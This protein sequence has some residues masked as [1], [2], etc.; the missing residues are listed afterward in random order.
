MTAAVLLVWTALA[1][2]I[3]G[4]A[5]D[6]PA[7]SG[8]GQAP[9]PRSWEV[10][11][12]DCASEIGRHRMTLFGNGT[13]RIKVREGETEEMRLRELAPDELSGYLGRLRAEDLSESESSARSA[14]G[15]WVD[16]CELTLDLDQGA[17]QV[18]RFGR[19]DSL[20]LALSRVVAVADEIDAWAAEEV[21]ATD[22][23]SDYRPRPGD[24]LER[25]DGVLFEVIALTSDRRGVELW[26]V[27]Q[28]LVVY[29]LLEEVVGEFVSLVERRSMP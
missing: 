15:D 2:A 6:E 17:E 27:D 10:L 28:P 13:V 23:P 9:D 4:P 12:Y 5:Q 24:V 20:S 29:V 26:G 16:T 22:F 3:P 7:R 25:K 19:F 21:V 18:F 14:A 8:S 11:D 1:A